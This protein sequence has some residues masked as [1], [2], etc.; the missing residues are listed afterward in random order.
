MRQPRE[1]GDYGV[2]VRTVP[3]LSCRELDDVVPF[4]EALGFAVTYRQARPNPY[5]SLSR[6]EVA[7]LRALM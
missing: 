3:I 4:Y 6:G 5:L 7:G 1:P 2:C